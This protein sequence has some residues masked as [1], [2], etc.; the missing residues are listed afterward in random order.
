MEALQRMGKTQARVRRGG[1]ERT[2]SAEELVPGDIVLL[3]AGDVVSADLRLLE[4]NRLQCDE[5]ALTGESVPV[6]K[7]TDPIDRDDPP[8]AER[9]NMAFKGTAVTD[10]SGLGVVVATGMDTEL[11]HISSLVESAES[12]ATPLERRL[13]QLGRRLI[14]LTVAIAAVVAA[15]GLIAGK[16]LVVMLET[17]IALA[18]AAVPEGLPVV[19]TL[20]LARGMRKMARRNAVV[21]RLSAVETLGTASLIFTDKT[22]TLTENHMTLA[23]LALAAGTFALARDGDDARILR[24]DDT[25]VELDEVP[26]LE[27]ALTVGALCNNASLGEDGSVG[28]PTEVALLEGAAAAGLHRDALLGRLPE[29]R[30][31]SF[32]PDLKLMAT[33][34][35]DDGGW[36]YA[37]KGAPEAVLGRCN[38][39]RTE[40]GDTGLDDAARE[41]WQNR[42]ERLAADGLRML[43]LAEKRADSADA[44][45]YADLTLLALTGLYDPPR[46]GIDTTLAA[47]QDAGIRIVMGTGDHAATAQAIAAEIGLAPPDTEAVDAS[48]LGDLADLD[49]SRREQL[50]DSAVFARI[51]PEQKLRLIDLY[52]DAGWVVGMTGDGVNDAPALKQADIGIAMGR[53]GTEVARQAA[54]I[55]LKDDAFETLV[56]AIE[57]GRTI[58]RNIRR[59]IVYLLSGNLA[60]IMAVSA[61]AVVGAPLP[62]LPLQILYIN[63]VS[64]VMPALALGLSPSHAGVMDEPP[65]AKDEPILN[66]GHWMAITGYGVLIAATVLTAFALAFLWLGLGTGQAVTIGFLTF[67][68]ARL[69]HVLNMRDADSP[70]FVNEITRNPMV[71]VSIAVGVGLLALAVW[72]PMAADVLSIRPLPVGGWLLVAGFS[73]LPLLLVQ[74]TKIVHARL[75]RSGTARGTD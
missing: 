14:W 68:F 27:A 17:A 50:L 38:R 16:A 12:S 32:D 57:H 53:R 19:A 25:E 75:R 24:D 58:F 64:D 69:V 7:G 42:S 51:S 46:P 60:E 63:F 29:E 65:R 28:D 62:L 31:V 20:A 15:A 73:A 52:Q 40:D 11:G 71:W 10:G 45:P 23:R 47:C 26:G 5:A 67:G 3:E 4:A 43:A 6:T 21:K 35:A 9:G 48:T 34:H 41:D 59:F 36:R 33:V 54:D 2:L 39:V 30:E 61:A 8:L 37:V 56:H 55:V 74:A 22:G 66:R 70:V 18:I 13:E 1:K 72:V 44:E 49:A